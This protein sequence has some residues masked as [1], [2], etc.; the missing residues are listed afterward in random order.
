MPANKMRDGL[1]QRGSTWSYVVRER[2]PGTGKAKPRWV[3]GFDTRAEARKA[4][5]AA[6]HATNRGTFVAPASL[7]VGEYLDRVDRR[8]R[9]RAQAVHCH[10]LP[11]KHQPIP[12]PRPGP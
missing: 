9:G 12:T 3:G 1:V 8:P 6:R 7:T 5:D 10:L 11:G 4:R 2:D